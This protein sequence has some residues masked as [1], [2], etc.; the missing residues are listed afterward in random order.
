MVLWE[1]LQNHPLDWFIVAGILCFGLLV[2]LLIGKRSADNTAIKKTLKQA[3]VEKQSYLKGVNYILSNDTDAAIEELTKVVQVNTE[4][5]E[6]YF[7]LGSLFRNKGEMERAIRIHQNIVMR[8]NLNEAMRTEA[9]YELS[10]DYK[11]AGLIR[12]AIA[13]FNE[14]IA[15]KKNYALAYRQLQELHEETKEWE[16]AYQTCRKFAKLSGDKSLN[17]LAHLMTEIGKQH[18]EEGDVNSARKCFKKAISIDA[19]CIQAY[20]ELGDYHFNNKDFK[21]AVDMWQKAMKVDDTLSGIIYPRLEEGYFQLGAFPKY[22]TLLR[23]KVLRD[24]NDLFARLAI[25]SI[26]TRKGKHEEAIE[27][28]RRALELRSDFIEARRQLAEILLQHGTKEEIKKEYEELI[29][30]MVLPLKSFQCRRCGFESAKLVWKCP[31]CHTWD[32][33]GY[34]RYSL[35]RHPRRQV[36]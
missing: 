29:G 12:R 3:A 7:A 20:L 16:K 9:L 11:K 13:S 15:R 19:K 34:K 14:V 36:A 22:E 5:V 33:M 1:H 35:K 31:Q 32:S 25:T 17:V 18:R 24:E 6:T 4:T 2:G 27:E 21:A 28:L 10:L 8:P 23:T 26:L 30:V